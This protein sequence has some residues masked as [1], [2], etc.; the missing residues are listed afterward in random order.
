MR[1]AVLLVLSGSLVL[2]SGAEAPKA[3]AQTPGTSTNAPAR[4]R[5]ATH[6]ESASE[7]AAPVVHV[8]PETGERY[9]EVRPGRGLRRGTLS[10]P[11][12]LVYVLGA[13]IGLLALVALMQRSRRPRAGHRRRS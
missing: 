12:W 2:L 7:D 5:A 8:D 9:R 3:L 13:A 1:V 10:A 6:G 11:S 4:S